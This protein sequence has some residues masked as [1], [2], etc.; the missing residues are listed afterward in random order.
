M[1]VCCLD[2]LL[3]HSSGNGWRRFHHRPL[4]SEIFVPCPCFPWCFCFFGVLFAVDFLGVVECFLLVL[5]GFKG[6]HGQN[7]LMCL[8]CFLVFF[9]NEG[10]QGKKERATCSH[11]NSEKLL[12]LG[13]T[14]KPRG[15]LGGHVR[16]HFV[17]RVLGVICSMALDRF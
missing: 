4:L 8:S 10:D 3:E 1:C 11:E 12:S 6:S 15:D 2:S 7:S 13:A 17:E 9:S 16:R 5:Q 14:C